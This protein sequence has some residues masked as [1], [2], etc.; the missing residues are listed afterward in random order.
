MYYVGYQKSGQGEQG[1]YTAHWHVNQNAELE[2]YVFSTF[3]TVYALEWIKIV[4]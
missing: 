4:I 1:G 3:E 2:K